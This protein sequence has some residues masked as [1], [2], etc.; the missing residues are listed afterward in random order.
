MLAVLALLATPGPTNTLLAA[1]GASVGL[2]RS[3]GLVAA[4]GA[5]YLL[6]LV[7]LIAVIGPLVATHGALTVGL[8]LAAALWLAWCAARLWQEAAE[9]FSL[10]G[11]PVTWTRMFLT[12]SVNPK[13]LVFAF[14]IFPPGGLGTAAPWLA[15]FLGLVVLAG[16]AWIAIGALIGRS[17]GVHFSPHRVWQAAAVIL[18]AFAVAVAGSALAAG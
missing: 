8:K 14:V 7:V 10:T 4:E 13:A 12:T 16:T 5:G 6:A 15:A 1:S 11:T 17:A 9:G 3:L 18:G 2:V